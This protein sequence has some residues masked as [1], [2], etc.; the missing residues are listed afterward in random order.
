M[1]DEV[2]RLNGPGRVELPDGRKID[3][4]GSKPHFDKSTGKWIEC[5]HTHDPQPPFD[6]PYDNLPRG[7]NPVPR[8][9]TWQDFWDALQ[10][11]RTWFGGGG[12]DDPRL[13]NPNNWA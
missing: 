8:P 13:D 4:P 6:P 9:S 11:L 7:S 12:N 5:P 10:H 3:M 2:G 1:I